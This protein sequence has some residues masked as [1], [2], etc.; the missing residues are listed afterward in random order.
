MQLCGAVC[1]VPVEAKKV[2]DAAV[3]CVF[4][5]VQLSSSQVEQMNSGGL[6]S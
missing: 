2:S 3:R 1:P 5:S 4:I 6:G